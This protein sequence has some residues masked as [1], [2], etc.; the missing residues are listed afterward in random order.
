MTL[1]D[2]KK[3]RS[4][5]AFQKVSFHKKQKAIENHF[6]VYWYTRMGTRRSEFPLSPLLPFLKHNISGKKY[7]FM[8]VAFHIQVRF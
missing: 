1:T 7:V 2:I 3:N 5:K 4:Y 6:Y 8:C